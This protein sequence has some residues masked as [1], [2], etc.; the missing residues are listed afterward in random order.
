MKANVGHTAAI[1]LTMSITNLITFTALF[2]VF[3]IFM[4]SS[5]RQSVARDVSVSFSGLSATGRTGV[6]LSIG[7]SLF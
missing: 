7:R 6:P 5:A 4:A 3:I 1:G 2:H